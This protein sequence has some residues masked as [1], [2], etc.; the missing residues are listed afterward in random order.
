M[1]IMMTIAIHGMAQTNF[2]VVTYNTLRFP[3][4]DSS[5]TTGG[6]NA[7]RL[8][9]FQ[10]IMEDINPDV[11]IF[12]EL[13]T[14]GG[15]N[16]LLDTLNASNLS[17]TFART[18]QAPASNG[19]TGGNMLFYNTALFS[20]INENTIPKTNTVL[21]PDGITWVQSTRASNIYRLNAS[22]PANPGTIVPIYFI[23]AHLQSSNRS[24]SSDPEQIPDEERRGLGAKDI[25]DYIQTNL[26]NTD[27]IIVVG[28]MN[29]YDETE[30]GY[31]DFT[32]NAD[33][34]ELLNDP[35]GAWQRDNQSSVS[36]FT[37]S[38]RVMNNAVGNG[39]A[40]G[41]LCDRF[42]FIFYNDDI[43]TGNNGV[44]YV[45]NTM[46]AYG[47]TDVDVNQSALSGS[48][49]LKQQLYNFTDHYPVVAE[50]T[51]DPS[52][53]M[54]SDCTPYKIDGTN[55]IIEDFST[56]AGQGFTNDPA[57]GQLCSNAWDFSGFSDAYFFGSV[58]VG[59][60]YARG[61][62]DGG[63]S[64]GGIYDNNH[65]LWIQPTSSDFTSGSVIMK[66]CNDTGNTI[67]SMRLSFDLCILNDKD[68][69]SKLDFYYSPD[70]LSFTYL[71]SMS[72]ISQ[73]TQ[74]GTLDVFPK[75]INLYNVNIAYQDC[76]FLKWTGDDVSGSGSRDEFGIDNIGVKVLE[77]PPCPVLLTVNNTPIA[78]GIY[79]ADTIT[80][81]GTVPLGG[82]VEFKGAD[83]ILLDN[84]FSVEGNLNVTIDE[85]NQ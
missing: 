10:D 4:S 25:M 39:G 60:D 42:D 65:K 63:S 44:G 58:N 64:Q 41:G 84:G 3:S 30:I 49:P 48:H 19:G 16:D 80:S 73:V 26:G 37:Q 33:Y 20:F 31:E 8:A 2:K 18:P 15:T 53:V 67:D 74:T 51:L 68:R 56:F 46:Q 24:N 76:F 61:G 82:T 75:S 66:I 69:S 23:S 17:K 47:T 36:K 5:M 32:I 29:F 71:P 57:P 7:D 9:A 81:L 70:S 62:T 83:C 14:V 35:L 13:R 55:T 59:N 40:G 52:V 27:N 79:Q 22:N 78:D 54:N 6:T 43:A 11:I 50:F 38:P 21:A 12:Q 45:S 1:V 34:T 72:E 77:A 28:D 85:C